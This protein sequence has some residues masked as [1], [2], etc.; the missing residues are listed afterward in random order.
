[1]LKSNKAAQRQGGNYWCTWFLPVKYG[2]CGKKMLIKTDNG[3]VM[4]MD[5]IRSILNGNACT[6]HTYSLFSLIC[7]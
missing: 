7:V 6:K 4:A 5:M 1:M 2:I 3:T